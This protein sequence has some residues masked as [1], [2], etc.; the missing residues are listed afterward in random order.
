ML[1]LYIIDKNP[2]V[3]ETT[4]VCL[5]EGGE[6]MEFGTKKEVS[7]YFPDIDS[8]TIGEKSYRYKVWF[9]TRIEDTLIKMAKHCKD[10]TSALIVEPNTLYDILWHP[11]D[12][13]N[14]SFPYYINSVLDSYM[15][16]ATNKEY[17]CKFNPK[18]HEMGSYDQLVYKIR[19]YCK[20]L[21]KIAPNYQDYRILAYNE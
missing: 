6:L 12:L 15:E 7:K 5:S 3:F 13:L 9:H 17:Y 16:L 20:A 8:A 10:R 14:I 21:L 18:V 1:H 11:E 2:R 4:G 19:T